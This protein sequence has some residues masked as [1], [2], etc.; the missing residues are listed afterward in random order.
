MAGAKGLVSS[1]AFALPVG[2]SVV[3]P[4]SVVFGTCFSRAGRGCFG[5]S[6]AVCGPEVAVE[7]AFGSGTTLSS[8]VCS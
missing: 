3:S 7:G 8:L 6:R 4:T 1:S 5:S 2:S